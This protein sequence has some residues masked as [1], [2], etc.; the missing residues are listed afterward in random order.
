MFSRCARVVRIVS[1]PSGPQVTLFAPVIDFPGQLI[2][3]EQ[4]APGFIGRN[5][6][7]READGSAKG[8]TSDVA[9]GQFE[10]LNM[11]ILN[12]RVKK[13]LWRQYH[14]IARSKFEKKAVIGMIYSAFQTAHF[15]ILL[16]SM[17]P[18]SNG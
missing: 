1:W 8:L 4:S 15:F 16:P 13:I 6:S 11:F 18:P 12:G 7:S 17:S 10:T 9:F 5:R 14:L 3:F 2:P